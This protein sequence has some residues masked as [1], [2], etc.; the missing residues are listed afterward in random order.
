VTEPRLAADAQA[1]MDVVRPILAPRKSAAVAALLLSE[2]Y[3]LPYEK[4]KRVEDAIK[5]LELERAQL[6][7]LD[8]EENQS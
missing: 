5:Y 4:V 2:Q 1:A 6:M 8:I 7:E 3:E